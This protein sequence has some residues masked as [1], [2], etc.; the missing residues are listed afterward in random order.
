MESSD[1]VA[2]RVAQDIAAY[3]VPTVHEGVGL[4]L[5][6]DW[7]HRQ[8]AALK[9]ALVAPYAAQMRDE[10]D[11]QLAVLSVQVVADDGEGTVV[12]FDPKADE[13][14]LAVSDPD[15]VPSR[16]VNLV[17]CGVR[18]KVVGCFMSA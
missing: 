9:A 1:Y 8:L 14:V 7:H 5:G 15:P 3:Q 11:G 6:A 17:S 4:P 12:V 18:G 2:H 13:F 10:R 16:N